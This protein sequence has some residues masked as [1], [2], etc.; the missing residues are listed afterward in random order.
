MTGERIEIS[1]PARTRYL[2]A[3]RDFFA[4][5]C[6]DLPEIRLDERARAEVLLVLQEGCIN[7]I[8]H[9]Q[10]G[11]RGAVVQVAFLLADDRLTIEI[12]DHGPGFDPLRIP[13]PAPELLQE[14]G[15]GVFIM[16]QSMDLVETR[17][18]GGDF[19]LSLTRLYE[20]SERAAETGK[21]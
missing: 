3:V 19:V 11:A 13:R 4:Q 8:R 20:N 9:G 10:T 5:L 18:E 15:Y 6:E 17:R 12:R 14:G 21:A 1:V 16:K 2:Q 7:A